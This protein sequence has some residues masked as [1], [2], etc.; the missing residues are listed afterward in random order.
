MHAYNKLPNAFTYALHCGS[1]N[2]LTSKNVIHF[3][4]ILFS[5]AVRQ[6]QYGNSDRDILLDDIHC[7]GLEESLL[8]CRA[9][10]SQLGADI[11]CYG[12][13]LAAVRCGGL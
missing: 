3:C 4:P 10:N 9:L 8:D 12:S 2:V 5:A 13:K 7:S 6:A 1:T 11:Q